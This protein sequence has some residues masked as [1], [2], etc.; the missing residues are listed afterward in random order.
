MVGRADAWC[1]QG[2]RRIEK[3]A[4]K[5]ERWEVN[6]RHGRFS[7]QPEWNSILLRRGRERWGIVSLD[8]ERGWLRR[9]AVE[10]QTLLD[11]WEDVAKET[12]QPK[13]V[14]V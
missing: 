2:A 10:A 4:R 5:I 8:K 6:R 7:V 11:E 13:A 1:F 3:E 9:E 12:V 14:K